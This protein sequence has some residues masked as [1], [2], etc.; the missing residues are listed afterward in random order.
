MI[1]EIKSELYGMREEKYKAFSEKLMPGA[2]NVLGVRLPQLRKLAKKIAKQ[3]FREYLTEAEE[4][5]HEE[6]MLKG[7][8]IGY[9]KM[10]DE[11]R[12]RWLDEFVPKMSNWAVCDSCCMGYSFMKKNR[13]FWF[14]YLRKFWE[15]DRE[16]E[17]RF[18]VVSF[19][20]H[21]ADQKEYLERIFTVL[22]SIDHEGYYVKMAVA[23]AVS[24]FFVSFPKETE[25]FLKNNHFDAFTQNK[26]IQK[27]WESYRVSKEDKERIRSYS[28]PK[29]RENR[30]K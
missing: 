13:E 14:S 22:D 19:L 28:V 12:I 21:F 27:I 17:I 11:E 24:V 1:Q 5:M 18:A 30:E 25:E 20:A 7:L 29:S 23:W 26:S 4:T 3:D 8:V 6:L 2:D 15:S 9:A 16:F 10:E